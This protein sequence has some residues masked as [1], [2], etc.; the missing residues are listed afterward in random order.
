MYD[1][2]VGIVGVPAEYDALLVDMPD[3]ITVSFAM[4]ILGD[5]KYCGSYQI[6][7]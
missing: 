7:S 4:S 5:M 3:I 1:M 6:F 2:I